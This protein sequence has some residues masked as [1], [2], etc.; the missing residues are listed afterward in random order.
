MIGLPWYGLDHRAGAFYRPLF[1][2][3]IV[4]CFT[5]K[6]NRQFKIYRNFYRIF[7]AQGFP[8]FGPS[9]TVQRFRLLL[10]STGG[11]GY[12]L[13]DSAGVSPSNTENRKKTPPLSKN[14]AKIKKELPILKNR[15]KLKRE[16]MQSYKK[17]LRY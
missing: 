10:D 9:G 13:A 1:Y 4:S 8:W 7:S 3:D 2:G 5:V 15:Q 16:F 14:P 11:G 12:G 17:S 6:V